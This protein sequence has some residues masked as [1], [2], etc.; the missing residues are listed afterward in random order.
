MKLSF[1]RTLNPF[2]FNG[3]ETRDIKKKHATILE[4]D[5]ETGVVIVG[6][7]PRLQ[8]HITRFIPL[9]NVSFMVPEEQP[10][11]PKEEKPVVDPKAVK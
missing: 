9:E 10:P 8:P 11:A 3:S 5:S 6:Q 1:V 2:P 7:N 4:Y